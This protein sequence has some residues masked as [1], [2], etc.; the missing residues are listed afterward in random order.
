M[1]EAAP[2]PSPLLLY[3]LTA[4]GLAAT[5]VIIPVVPD[6][7]DEFGAGPAVGGLILAAGTA[8]GIVMA[9]LLGWLADRLGRRRVLTACLVLVGVSGAAFALASSVPQLLALRIVQGLGS[10]A[11]ANMALV[12]IGD[13]WD[14]QERLS[15]LGRNAAVLIGAAA[16]GPP[17]GGLLGE[18]AGWRATSVA[19]LP[20]LA[21]AVIVHQRLPA[22]RGIPAAEG[23]D[24]HIP[25]LGLTVRAIVRTVGAASLHFVL[26]FGLLQAVLPFA[27]AELGFSANQRGL[28]IGAAALPAA[29]ASLRSG[30]GGRAPDTTSAAM[31]AFVLFALGAVL[32]TLNGSAV[33]LIVAA[34]LLGIGSGRVVPLLQQRLALEAP[35]AARA[36]ATAFWGSGVRTGQTLGPLVAGGLLE[37]V[38]LQPSLLAIAAVAVA[39]A[40]LMMVTS[41]WGWGRPAPA[42]GVGGT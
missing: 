38:G 25:D 17:I 31:R 7:T 16:L 18:L 4:A 20:M 6:I 41:R 19:Y 3:G 36:T 39:I 1:R 42:S 21:L 15:L 9:P 37:M 29:V 23:A 34:V 12:L 22:G 28:L 40:G 30:R 13:N 26:Y 32:I 24:H 10:V 8:P 33:T 5:T 27:A 35:P 11:V 2:R 14:G